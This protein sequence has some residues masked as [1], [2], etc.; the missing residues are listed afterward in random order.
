M[1]VSVKGIDGK[2]LFIDDDTNK[3]KSVLIQ[4]KSGKVNVRDIRDLRGTVERE[5]AAIGVFITLARPTS[6]MVKEAVTAG[7]YRSPGWNVDYPKVQILTIQELFDG[8]IIEM[9]PTHATFKTAK[10]E[11]K[12]NAEVRKRL[13]PQKLKKHEQEKLF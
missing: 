2:I 12:G 7:F 3:P 1:N 6:A 11:V 5:K 10:K 13:S 4:V 9:P 8:K